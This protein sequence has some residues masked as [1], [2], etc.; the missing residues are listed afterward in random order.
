MINV[1][2]SDIGW[3][4]YEPSTAGLDLV[5]DAVVKEEATGKSLQV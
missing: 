3:D 4:R 2:A 1:T 5:I